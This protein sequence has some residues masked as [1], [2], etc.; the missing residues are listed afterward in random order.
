MGRCASVDPSECKKEI[1]RHAE[2]LRRELAR[3][4]LLDFIHYTFPGY[5]SN[6]FEREV[7]ER[8]EL[9][10]ERVQAGKRPNLMLFAPPR[11]GKT[12]IIAR[13]FPAWVLGKRPDYQVLS[14]TNSED[15]ANTTA[16]EVRGILNSEEYRRVFPHVRMDIERAD[17]FHIEGVR[18]QPSYKG[19]SVRSKIGGFGANILIL[20]DPIAG[21]KEANSPADRES[22]WEW[23]NSAYF[24]RL[25]LEGGG[26]LLMMTRFH[27]SD[28]AGRII[29]SVEK[30]GE[31]WEII[32]YP[33]IAEED[34][35]HRTM[36]EALC[37][38]R[39]TLQDL[40][41]IEADLVA[42]D[43][44]YEW[45]SLYQQRPQ[46]TEGTA[47]F[48]NAILQPHLDKALT[49]Q[50]GN[51]SRIAN[52]Q[53][54]EQQYEFLKSDLGMLRV[55]EEPLE[56]FSYC[57]AFDTAEGWTNALEDQ[58]YHCFGILRRGMVDAVR[59]HLKI[60]PAARIRVG[61]WKIPALVAV[62][63]ARNFDQDEYARLIA[64]VLNWYNRAYCL[65]ERNSYG[66]SVL[67]VLRKIYP[68]QYLL[69]E[70]TIAMRVDPN[71]VDEK[72][73]IYTTD[74][75]KPTLVDNLKAAYRD[76]KLTDPD[77]QGL[78]EMAHFIRQE[79]RY[80]AESRYHDDHVSMRWLL[81]EC[82]RQ[83]PMNAPES[84]MRFVNR[85]QHIRVKPEVLDESM[86]Y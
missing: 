23:I 68:V 3:R 22:D 41:N 64:D 85:K 42:K 81:W 14:A 86:G 36:G 13:R 57:G 72:L 76:K 80:C 60:N 77:E 50:L 7:C 31:A 43:S 34:E 62:F 75:N 18:V 35:R 19:C 10:F 16:M 70:T 20:D 45:L 29:E 27:P 65:G 28:P 39:C 12:E 4:H 8:L 30:G 61:E 17:A 48:S 78:E 83:A 40:E 37:P 66:A 55:W 79:N 69:G 21:R 74:R 49:P 9:F 25:N 82:N 71:T 46:S 5:T 59:E 84:L 73:G 51:I 38:H 58:D 24:R 33:A 47:V 52:A 26:K 2:G 15:L 32:S 53:P 54:G 56:G 44:G 11:H 6:W 67:Q 63:H 1:L